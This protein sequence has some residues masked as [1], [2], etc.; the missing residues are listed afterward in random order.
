MSELFDDVLILLKEDLSEE[1]VFYFSSL[2]HLKF[3]HIHP[4]AD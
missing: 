3:I 2:I 1:E 4:F